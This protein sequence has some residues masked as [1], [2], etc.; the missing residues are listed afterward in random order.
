MSCRFEHDFPPDLAKQLLV[1]FV[2]VKLSFV[3]FVIEYF[4]P[5][6][7]SHHRVDLLLLT[8]LLFKQPEVNIFI[9]DFHPACSAKVS[10]GED[11]SSEGRVGVD[12]L[13]EMVASQLKYLHFVGGNLSSHALLIV[14]SLACL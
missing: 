11:E 7:E 4:V 1:I 8:Y 12:D 3:V 5:I 13:V 6:F 2:I 9:E 14:S 10:T